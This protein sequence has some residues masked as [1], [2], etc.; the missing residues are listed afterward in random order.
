MPFVSASSYRASW[1]F[2]NA[3]VNTIYPALFRKVPALAYERE[4]IATPDGDFLDLD[5][6]KTSSRRLLIG[7]HGL[8]GNA[9]RHYLRG[10]FSF[11]GKNG[12]NTLGMNFRSCSGRMNKRLRM[13][14]MGETNDLA[15]V[16][17]Y[18]LKQGAY[19]EIVLSGFSLGGNVV[20]KYLG[21]SG[22][23]LSP[24]IRGGVVFSVPC[25]IPAAN[26]AIAHWR[27]RIYLKRFMSTLNEKLLEK[28]SLYPTYLDL[29]APLPKSFYEFDE[30]FTGPIHG[31]SGAQ[32]YW[33]SCSSIH[34]M[35]NICRPVLVIN[36]LDDTFL[37][38]TC[39]P[40]EMAAKHPFVY[41]ETPAYGGHCGFY[42][43]NKDGSWWTERRA[44]SFLE[45]KVLD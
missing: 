22:N 40:R 41:L 10:L 34:F 5:W 6:Q 15:L 26:V 35:P 23:Q 7:L 39:F 16:I 9:D 17:Q 42:S 29:S 18:V 36:A 45:E 14:N 11:F 24:Q 32:D 3:H 13:Y 20:L 4:T 30:Q 1:P 33:Q 21:E 25:D 44:L 37:A 12:W 43:S 2:T 8:E 28:A 31:Y 27:N 38:P 19:D